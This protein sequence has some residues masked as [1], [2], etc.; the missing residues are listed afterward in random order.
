MTSPRILPA[1]MADVAP[2]A[3]LHARSW[4][5]TYAHMLPTEHV[6]SHLVQEHAALWR[7]RFMRADDPAMR[8]WKACPDMANG[9]LAGFVCALSGGDG[10]LLDNLHVA[11][12]WQGRG[13]GRALFHQVRDWASALDPDAALYLWVLASN[14]RARQFY[15]RLGGRAG[16]VHPIAVSP[17]IEVPALRYVWQTEKI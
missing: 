9:S 14:T 7:D 2:I 1:T 17:G 11:A 5:A 15:D 3:E 12:T 13:I 6:R 16:R 8:I 4:Q 10:I